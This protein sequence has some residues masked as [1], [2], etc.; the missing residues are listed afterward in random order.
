MVIMM[1]QTENLVI[2]AQGKARENGTAGDTVRVRN[3]NSG[4][5]VEA[6][7]TGPDTVAVFPLTQPPASAV[8]TVPA[9]TC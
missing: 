3:A 8:T 6:V 9:S 5:I 1:Y 4:K 2:T 7:V